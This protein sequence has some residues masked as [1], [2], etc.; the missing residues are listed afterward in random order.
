MVFTGIYIVKRKSNISNCWSQRNSGKGYTRCI[1]NTRQRYLWF[2]NLIYKREWWNA[3]LRKIFCGTIYRTDGM[4]P[5]GTFNQ[6][7]QTTKLGYSL[8]WIP[9]AGNEVSKIRQLLH[10]YVYKFISGVHFFN[11][12]IIS[13]H[14]CSGTLIIGLVYCIYFLL[15]FLRFGSEHILPCFIAQLSPIPAVDKSWPQVC[16]CSWYR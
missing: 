8:I 10:G 9:L 14:W 6:S 3:K 2:I 11:V 5:N 4:D 12:P 16:S 7:G 1:Q 15:S 13:M